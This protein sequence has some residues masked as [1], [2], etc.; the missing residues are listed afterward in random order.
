ML[1]TCELKAHIYFNLSTGLFKAIKIYTLARG[2]TLGVHFRFCAKHI[3]H[4]HSIHLS[5]C[6][7]SSGLCR[8]GPPKFVFELAP[9]TSISIT[10][11]ITEYKMPLLKGHF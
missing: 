1:Q 2:L 4:I 9:L 10:V 3:L 5:I 8:Q 11:H 6:F 7:V